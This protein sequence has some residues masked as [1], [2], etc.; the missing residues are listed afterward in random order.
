M[1]RSQTSAR[2]YAEAAFAI[3]ERDG[4][5]DAWLE[6]LNRVAQLAQDEPAARLLVNPAVPLERRIAV[7]DEIL[8]RNAPPP[9]RNLVQ[10][11]LRRGRVELLPGV[12]AEFRRLVNRRAGITTAVATSA[13]ELPPD[14]VKELSERLERLTGGKVEL[15]LRVDESLLGGI[16]VR[17][18][19]RL[20]DGS[21]RSRLERLRSRVVAGTI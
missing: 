20:I 14:E 9:L 11:V 3:A 10:L 1:P 8:D 12:A 7:T 18:G 15:E 6:Q 13:S 5:T 21:V 2:R 16:V 4:T 17:V 19:D